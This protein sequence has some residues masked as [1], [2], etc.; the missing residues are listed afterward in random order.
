MFDDSEFLEIYQNEIQVRFAKNVQANFIED[1]RNF[2]FHRSL[3]LSVPELRIK[4]EAETTL[5]SSLAIV[6]LKDYLLEWN[7]WSEL[8]KMQIEMAFD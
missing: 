1:L 6:L 5:K 3:P 4:Q 2:T 7:N 8:G